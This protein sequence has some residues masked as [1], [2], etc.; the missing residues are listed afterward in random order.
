MTDFSVSLKNEIMQKLSKC[1]K[2]DLYALN[3]DL[4]YE[5]IE[6]LIKQLKKSLKDEEA[7]EDNELLEIFKDLQTIFFSCDF[8]KKLNITQIMKQQVENYRLFFEKHKNTELDNYKLNSLVEM[9]RYL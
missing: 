2:N 4:I 7:E 3:L 5:K 8:T 6:I 9:I 1:E